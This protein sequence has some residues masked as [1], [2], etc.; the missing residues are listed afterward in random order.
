MCTQLCISPAD[1]KID[2]GYWRPQRYGKHLNEETGNDRKRVPN[3]LR[4]LP[5]AVS[6][7]ISR[8]VRW[9]RHVAKRDI[10]NR[11]FVRKASTKQKVWKTCGK[12][13][14][15]KKQRWCDITAIVIINTV[16]FWY[17][18]PGN[19]VDRSTFRRHLF[20]RLQSD[21]NQMLQKHMIILKWIF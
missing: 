14:N 20:S 10:R 7:P 3:N 13:Q 18:T 12:R 2:G 19:L 11:H 8:R 4:Y 17:V 16:A 9:T 5:K 6:V 15:N 21:I 1:T